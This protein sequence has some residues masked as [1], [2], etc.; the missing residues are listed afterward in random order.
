MKNMAAVETRN[1]KEVMAS[2][3]VSPTANKTIGKIGFGVGGN[4]PT[5]DDT[6]LTNPYIKNISGYK[7]NADNSFTFTYVLAY[8]EAN[9]KTIRE[10]GLYCNDGKTLVAREVK[11]ILVKDVDTSIEG[12]ITIIF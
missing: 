12:S 4:L 11:D 6:A 9:G 2:Q 5:P 8:N 1:L 10:I 3:A 7:V